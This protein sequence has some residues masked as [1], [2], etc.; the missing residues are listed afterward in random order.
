M[1]RC[2]KCNRTF[3]DENQ[4][5]CTFDGGLLI[6]APAFDPNITIRATA[7]DVETYVEPSDDGVT[8][9]QLPPPNERPETGQ[10][11]LDP[12]ETIM[13]S[14]PTTMFQRPTGPTGNATSA[15]LSRAPSRPSVP[16]GATTASPAAP[17][18]QRQAPSAPLPAK[19]KGSKL[20]WILAAL[21]VLLLIGGGAIAAVFF[22]VVKP[23]LEQFAGQP[24]TPQRPPT[25][26]SEETN[27]NATATNT[28]VA[29]T[30]TETDTFIPPADAQKFTNSKDNLDGKLAE[31]YVDFYFHY[32]G[33]WQSDANAGVA[34]A[35]NFARVFKTVK[36]GTEE[37]T[38]ESVAVSWYNSNGTYDTD[39]SIFPSRVES[40]SAQLSKSLPNYK[41]VSE[42]P[43][44][45]NSL[46][47]Y[48]F[49]FTGVSKDPERGD[50][51]YWGRAIFIPPSNENEKSGV[52]IIMLAT[53]RASEVKSEE[54]VGVKGDM[55]LILDS[56]R[57]GRKD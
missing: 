27:K 57:L 25:T 10:P 51:P 20:P 38:P 21:F 40:L 33:S 48:D 22:V 55:S 41:K 56:F 1:K 12:N 54:D 37:Y 44:L 7:A 2:P 23:R 8:S 29:E 19:K 15:D 31:H 14:A 6:A 16:L 5:F 43:T 49:H 34:G 42:G 30:K 36:D 53:A 4:K 45:V 39:V 11:P 35:S 13:A 3:P 52:A 46:K 28:P 17:S 47:A 32:P 24:E 9:R 18:P 50:L 26:T